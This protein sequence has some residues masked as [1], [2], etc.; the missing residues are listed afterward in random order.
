MNLHKICKRCAD[1]TLAVKL[2]N[3][4]SE[5]RVQRPNPADLINRLAARAA[6]QTL[7]I[8]CLFSMALSSQA[9]EVDVLLRAVGF[10]LTGSDNAAPKTIDRANCVFRVENNT[11]Y[12]NNIHTDRITTEQW[13][14]GS[15]FGGGMFVKLKIHGD[16]P[17]VERKTEPLID[18]GSDFKREWKISHPEDFQPHIYKYNETELDLKTSDQDRVN[19]AWAYIFSHGCTGKKSPF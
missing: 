8:S 7:L 5:Q 1:K 10:A 13:R 6:A 9:E 2:W 12:L 11:F 15:A 19:R 17:V 18:D 3:S 16:K 4:C 14:Q